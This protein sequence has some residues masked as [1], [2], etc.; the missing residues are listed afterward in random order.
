MRRRVDV[1][2]RALLAALFAST[3]M[4]LW[5]AIGRRSDFLTAFPGAERPAVYVAFLGVAVVGL[6]SL[7]GLWRWR[8][9]AIA[10]YGLSA[11]VAVALDIIAHAPLAH[12]LTVITMTVVVLLLSY[13]N[14]RR[15]TQTTMRAA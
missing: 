8:P 1:V 6:V 14:R 11:G 9:W 7:I 5:I 15:F 12:R 3:C 2:L 13:A 10:L 4:A